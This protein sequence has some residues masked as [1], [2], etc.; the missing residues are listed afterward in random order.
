MTLRFVHIVSM[1][2]WFGP[3]LFIAGDA[4]RSIA[5]GGD[6]APLRARLGLGGAIAGIGGTLTLL[7]GL[8]LIVAMR[9]FGAVARPIHFGLLLSLVMWAVGAVGVGGA[10]R[11]LD[12]GIAV[13]APADQ[14]SPFIRRMSMFTGIT[15]NAP[16]LPDIAPPAG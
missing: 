6:L 2:A 1:A 11:K 3:M 10:V 7:S 12:R 9:G 15:L 13:G 5:A 16:F 8:G 4:R 14:L